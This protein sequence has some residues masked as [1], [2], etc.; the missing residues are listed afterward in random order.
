[1]KKL[2]IVILL[3]LIPVRVYAACVA[4]GGNW[5]ST[6]DLA[7]V[8]SCV[9]QADAGDTITVSA[10]DGSEDWGSQLAIT[11]GVK[12][13]GPGAGSLT[14]TSTFVGDNSRTGIN[15]YLIFYV[16]STPANNDPFEISGVTWDLNDQCGFL[17]IDNAS[18]TY[19]NNK[20]NIHD[21]IILDGDRNT[22]TFRGQVYGVIHSNTITQTNTDT[23]YAIISPY[24]K[25]ADSWNNLA[26]DYG[27]EDVLY[28]EDN[29]I[30]FQQML[31]DGGL[32]GR[33][34]LRYNDIIFGRDDNGE[35]I[36]DAHGNQVGANNATMGTEIYGNSIDYNAYSGA[37]FGH[38]GGKGIA[39]YNNATDVASYLSIKISEEYAD[40][41]TP[42]TTGLGG[43]TQHVEDS[44]YFR[45]YQDG[46]LIVPAINQECC[47]GLVKGPDEDCCYNTPD[48]ILE[49]T[50]WF[51]DDTSF[52]GTEGVGCGT[53]VSRPETC[54]T[55]VGYW[56]TDQ[57]CSVLTDYVGIEPTTPISGTLYKCTSTDTWESYFTPYTYPHPLRGADD[58]APT[59]SN[60]SSDHANGT[61]GESEVIDIDVYFSEQ[62]T[63]TGV[64]TVTL[65][66]GTTDRECEIAEISVA[67]TSGTCNY[68]VQAGDISADLEVKTIAGTI[69]DAASNAMSVFT[70]TTNLAANK[71]IVIQTNIAPSPPYSFRCGTISGGTHQ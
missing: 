50:D 64:I 69:Q 14:I 52:D 61:F 17:Y 38:R 8:A 36:T 63:S 29:T 65:E 49:N 24:G 23:S 66:T 6:P 4:D 21:N 37:L 18:T 44:Y 40:V 35:T 68:T 53:L 39:F 20:I 10:G 15:D 11:K 3:V 70:P 22:F 41:D 31:N 56:A 27:S 30:T 71:D 32:G 58:T 19:K 5:A 26:F 55:G 2:L 48:G 54:T 13:V 16:P 33:M 60:V 28:V 62:V 51:Q 1:M 43:S 47:S 42:P 7:S 57:S 25:N 45:N 59:I 12:I 67:A 46:N 9:S 34:V